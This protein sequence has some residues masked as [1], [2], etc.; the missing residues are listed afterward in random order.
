MLEYTPYRGSLEQY[1]GL[2]SS[3]IDG[4][5]HFFN[6]SKLILKIIFLL[7]LAC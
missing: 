2:R 6:F 3:A 1:F 4:K 7:L 5:A